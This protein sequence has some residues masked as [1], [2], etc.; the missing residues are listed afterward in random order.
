M[1]INY[2]IQAEVVDIQSD[3]PQESDIFFVDTNVW[4]W[5]TYSQA[6][7]LSLL[8]QTTDYPLYISK[9]ISAKSLL[10]Y[11]GLSLAE[12]A[13]NIEAAERNIFMNTHG[14]IRTKEYRHNYPTERAKVVAEVS[15]AWNQIKAI[16]A[17]INLMIDEPT[18][19]AALTRFQ[20]YLMVTIC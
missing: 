17:P 3:Q 20:T 6:S 9:A 15:Y 2:T 1:A 19:D 4:Y 8:Y 11:T 7:S 10:L 12:L 14:A 16:A 5:H 18:A 13:H